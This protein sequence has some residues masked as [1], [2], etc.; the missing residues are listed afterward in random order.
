MEP[1]ITENKLGEYLTASARRRR[2]IIKTIQEEGGF[3]AAR[4]TDEGTRRAVF[5]AGSVLILDE[6]HRDIDRLTLDA[7]GWPSVREGL[8]CRAERASLGRPL[9][10][11][12]HSA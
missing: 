6:I 4:R 12:W 11:R 10:R 9:V 7:Y 3:P 1:K 8:G 2:S 5:E